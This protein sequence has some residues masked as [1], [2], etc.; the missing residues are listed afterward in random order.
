M[1][2]RLLRILMM[3]W[4][5]ALILVY[6]VILSEASA[7]VGGEILA[8]SETPISIEMQAAELASSPVFVGMESDIQMAW[9]TIAKLAA[10][11]SSFTEKEIALLPGIQP[12]NE[13]SRDLSFRGVVKEPDGT[14]LEFGFDRKH[15]HMVGVRVLKSD[16]TVVSVSFSKYLDP[17]RLG[18]SYG[19][20]AGAGAGFQT[21][22][23]FAFHSRLTSPDFAFIFGRQAG[24]A[25]GTGRVLLWDNQGK[26]LKDRTFQLSGDSGQLELEKRKAIEDARAEVGLASP[27]SLLRSSPAFR[28]LE[29]NLGRGI[30]NMVKWSEKLVHTSPDNLLKVFR[31]DELTRHD[32]GGDELYLVKVRNKILWTVVYNDATQLLK[33]ATYN[34]GGFSLQFKN[35][36]EPRLQGGILDMQESGQE[37]SYW[38]VGFYI[39]KCTP[40]LVIAVTGTPT[41]DPYAVGLRRSWYPPSNI[42]AKGELQIWSPNGSSVLK[43]VVSSPMSLED[44]LAEIETELTE[45]GRSEIGWQGQEAEQRILVGSD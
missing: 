1:I 23:E 11:Y 19:S 4:T 3:K 8:A 42:H 6:A 12:K 9:L 41:P 22:Y 5:I 37:G 24:G 44:A 36:T 26:F 18:V 28:S 40:R 34:D 39:G 10:Q 31:G 14:E 27:V 21:S 35:G 16:G 38:L 20:F 30:V 25:T 43:K 32:S 33:C 29:K 13:Q 15:N 7:A 17:E 45:A 2:L